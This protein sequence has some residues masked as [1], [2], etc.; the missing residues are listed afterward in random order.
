MWHSRLYASGYK[1]KAIV[2]ISIIN[3]ASSSS[4]SRMGFLD[5]MRVLLAI[6]NVIANLIGFFFAII[7]VVIGIVALVFF[8]FFIDTMS[9][10]LLYLNVGFALYVAVGVLCTIFAVAAIIGSY[11]ACFPANTVLKSIAIFFLAT[12]L[13]IITVIF[14]LGLIG[15]ILAFVYRDIVANQFVGLLDRVINESYALDANSTQIA[16]SALQTTLMCCGVNGP[17]DFA[18]YPAYTMEY[19]SVLPPGCC[20]DTVPITSCTVA[21]ARQNG[22]GVYIRDLLVQYYNGVGGVG[23]FEIVVILLL[24]LVELVLIIL[25]VA[26]KNEDSGMKLV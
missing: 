10:N 18:K 5:V 3:R 9:D 7:L 24:M 14:I 17:A 1:Y 23:I 19:W 2:Y 15:V 22:C 12:H 20:N 25:V 6:I 21:N 8:N 13:I 26:K 11:L 4:S 16:V